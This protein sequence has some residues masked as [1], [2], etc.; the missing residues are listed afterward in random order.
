VVA[1]STELFDGKFKSGFSND[2]SYPF[3]VPIKLYGMT[4]VLLFLASLEVAEAVAV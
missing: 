1:S 3:C 2:I 4:L